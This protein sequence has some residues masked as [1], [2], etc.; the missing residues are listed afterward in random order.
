MSLALLINSAFL[1]FLGFYLWRRGIYYY[2]SLAMFAAAFWAF[3]GSIENSL[4]E[5][6]EKIL[7]SKI[8][9]IGIYSL[10]PLWLL[11]CLQYSKFKK[12]II[13]ILSY[14]IWIVPIIL[15][16]LTITNEH[17]N[18]FWSSV[19]PIDD[20]ITKGLIYGRGVGVYLAMI[21]SYLLIFLGV[22]TLAIYAFKTT[23]I[24]KFQIF[25]LFIGILIPWIANFFYLA[26][27]PEIS[28]GIDLTPIA[29]AVTGI[30]AALSIFKYKLSDL[31]PAAKDLVY[32]SLEVGVIVINN[33]YSIVDFNPMAKKI[34]R[35]NLTNNTIA[36][37]VYLTKGL[38]L[39][40]IIK[41]GGNKVINTLES[42]EWLD[43]HINDLNDLGGHLIGKMILIY[44]ITK[45]KEIEQKLEQA[46]KFFSDLTNF[47]PDSIFV[48]NTNRKIVFWNKAM[49][50]LTGIKSK[51]II[52]KD[53]NEYAIPFYGQKRP[54]LVDL[55]LDNNPSSDSWKLYKNEKMEI[56]GDI[57]SIKTYNKILKKEGIYLW[58]LAQPIYDNTGKIIYAIESIR[59]VN[60]IHKYQEGLKAKIDELSAIN[61]IMV[62]REI[63]MI[64]L[65]EELNLLKAKIESK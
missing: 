56:E 64:K 34:L 15:F 46:N 21:Y 12:N 47:L 49:E 37:K 54:M 38:N 55:I 27:S 50:K 59:D 44:N 31:L 65:K 13:K 25:T 18:L 7:W 10:A 20:D 1:I 29:F 45:K 30:F 42:N 2:F 26:Y 35:D 62:N 28:Q 24:Q 33:D 32:F 48:I 23:K 4:S 57:I 39:K 17:H 41:E 5:I 51:D 63:K 16:L 60:D 8:A 22:L 43:I 6:S 19:V 40:T 36:E 11:F 9:Y 52:G 61:K 14:L 53:N 3:S 58:I